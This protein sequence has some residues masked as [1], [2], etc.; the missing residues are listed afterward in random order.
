M[1]AERD[2]CRHHDARDRPVFETG[3]IENDAFAA[4]LPFIPHKANHPAI[5]FIQAIRLRRKHRLATQ[6]SGTIRI[7]L[8]TRHAES[9]PYWIPIVTTVPSSRSR[10]SVQKGRQGSR[11]PCP[12]RQQLGGE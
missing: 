12:L 5:F 6:T 8:A 7:M 2:A 11:R 3:C 1:E 4:L 10:S 9:P